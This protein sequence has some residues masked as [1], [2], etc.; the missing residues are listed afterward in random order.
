VSNSINKIDYLKIDTQ[1]FEAEVLKGAS[2]ALNITSNIEIELTFVNY[3]NKKTNFLEIEF[4]I[5]NKFEIFSIL[6]R[7]NLNNFQLKWCDV[8]YKK[9]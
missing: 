8:I 7:Y 4:L 9:K 1:G 6:P 5:D 3:Y 2:D